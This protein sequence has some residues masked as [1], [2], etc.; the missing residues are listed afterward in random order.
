M[1]K[2]VTVRT[3]DNIEP[4]PNADMIEVATVDG[5]NVVVKKNQFN[6]G[7]PCVFFEVDAFLPANDPRFEFL[8]KSGVKTDESGQ[9]RIRLKTIK[10]RKQLS[11]GLVLPLEEF[12]EINFIEKHD[13]ESED[14]SE[15]LNVIKY[16]RPEP[17]STNAARSFPE[18]LIKTDETRIQNVYK[19]YSEK[20]RDETYYATLKLDG[21]S[22]T[23]AYLGEDMKDYWEYGD[24]YPDDI[25]ETGLK[26]IIV[27]YDGKKYGELVVCSRN[28]QLKYSNDSHFWKAVKQN[29]NQLLISLVE[30]ALDQDNVSVA[31]QGEV[32]GPGIQGNKEKLN[33][34]QFYAFNIL[35]IKDRMYSPYSVTLGMFEHY[36]IQSVPLIRDS[37]ISVFNEFDN[38]QD[39]LSFA[40]GP[41]M[42]NDMREGVVFKSSLNSNVPSFK[43]ISNKFLLAGGDE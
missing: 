18:Y 30:M 43:C 15:V 25:E 1:R 31:I 29:D 16:E 6:V 9:E 32:C 23:V 38:L 42:N 28:L 33:D 21:S 5:W 27:S 7:D 19:K 10:L 8:R 3:I 13:E 4:I 12:P 20:Y 17:K 39:L 37:V 2:L 11:Q 24:S 22:C 36:Q 26:S 14:Y 35:N 34:F 40:D 41:S